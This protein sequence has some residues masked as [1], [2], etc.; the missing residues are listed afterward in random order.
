VMVQGNEDSLSFRAARS[1]TADKWSGLNPPGP[2]PDPKT[3]P[4]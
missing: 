3:G 1:Q 4:P 2:A